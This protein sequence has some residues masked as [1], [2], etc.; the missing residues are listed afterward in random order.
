MLEFS[1][2]VFF[3]LSAFAQIPDYDD[4][5]S[6]IFTDKPIY[7][8]TD[9]VVIT[10][11]APSWNAEKFGIDSIGNFEGNSIKLSTGKH[12]L[13]PYKLTETDFNSGIF[14]G[15]VILTGF[16]HDV[17]GDGNSDTNPRTI[18]NG[19]T[20]GFLETERGN[21][22]TISFE[23]ADGV[24]LTHSVPIS[25]NIGTIKFLEPQYFVNQEATI[26]IIDQD[27]NLNPEAIDQI[28][29][30]IS[31]DSDG[32]GIT[33]NSSET[34]E[35][36]GVFEA[37]ITFSQSFVSSGNRLLV[38]PG[39]K[40]YAK[41]EDRTLPRPYSISDELDIVAESSFDSNITPLQR[42]IVEKTV[43]TDSSGKPL[44]KLVVNNQLQIVSKVLNTQNFD[45]NFVYIVQV[46][47]EK[48]IIMTLSWIKGK[49]AANQSLELSQSWLPTES[50]KYKVE[51]FVWNSLKNPT[52]IAPSISQ[53]IL[54]E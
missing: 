12:S 3:I 40:L 45:Q 47:N 36:S 35:D 51:S 37:T 17:D 20:N 18:G 2:A 21:G 49:F 6:P 26:R 34:D 48:G 13:E 29:I 25:W 38:I 31:S 28:E 32:A 54:I 30:E 5:Y 10:I 42:T 53:T 27:M 24:V 33:V 8:W 4:P 43:I 15:E 16:S 22:I 50:G 19:P 1:F 7:T 41:Y 39:D 44:E 52:P 23:F 9:K 11:I 14:V 46:T